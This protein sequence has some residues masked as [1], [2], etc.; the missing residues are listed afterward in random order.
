MKIINPKNEYY[1]DE[2]VAAQLALALETEGEKLDEK[3]VSLGVREV[4]NNPLRGKY[5]I[6]LD[7]DD[8]FIGMLLT[9]PEW[10]DWRCAEVL[11][12]HSVYIKSEYRGKQVF[13]KLYNE[14]KGLVQ[15]RE[16]LAGIRLY[17]DKTNT[18]A[19]EVYNKLGMTDQHYNLFEW[20]KN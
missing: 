9:L 18:R 20:L 3:T 4:I 7:E 10:S 12:I 13:K 17:V 11:W 5:Y 15:S 6:A 1:L 14:I 19:I 16:D 8:K 2:M